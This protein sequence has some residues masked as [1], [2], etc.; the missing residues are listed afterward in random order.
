MQALLTTRV[1]DLEPKSCIFFK[2]NRDGPL[3]QSPAPDWAWITKKS[4][5]EVLMVISRHV[6]KFAQH[7]EWV[8]AF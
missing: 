7:D 5:K 4:A 8:A 1:P 3:L 6:W 2:V